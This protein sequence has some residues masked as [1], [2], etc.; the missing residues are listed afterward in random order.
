MKDETKTKNCGREQFLKE[1]TVNRNKKSNTFAYYWVLQRPFSFFIIQWHVFH[2]TNQNTKIRDRFFLHFIYIFFSCVLSSASSFRF[3]ILKFIPISS[4]NI[5]KR[6]KWI[7][8]L[9]RAECIA[10]HFLRDFVIFFD[11]IGRFVATVFINCLAGPF[12]RLTC[13]HLVVLY[14]YSP[15]VLVSTNTENCWPC[16]TEPP[17]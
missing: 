17:E 5:P 1:K 13:A 14:K 4:I 11:V 15:T 10:M 12:K 8:V 16:K 9:H 3:V 7:S 2:I 6:E